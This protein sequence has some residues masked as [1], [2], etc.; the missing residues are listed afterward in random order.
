ML[1]S[2]R[3]FQPQVGTNVTRLG[4]LNTC[5]VLRSVLHSTLRELKSPRKQSHPKSRKPL[6]I[7]LI[8]AVKV[9]SF[10]ASLSCIFG[11]EASYNVSNDPYPMLS[12]ELPAYRRVN[13]E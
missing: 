4:S 9:M 1:D 10:A 5:N 12:N 8:L 2:A 6:V 11:N 3:K 7:C 13:L